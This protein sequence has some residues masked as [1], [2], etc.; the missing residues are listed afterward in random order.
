MKRFLCLLI[1]I[2]LILS[3]CPVTFAAETVTP[4][5][6]D[7]IPES[8]YII[9]PDTIAYEPEV[10]D[11]ILE[12]RDLAATTSSG[13][14]GGRV[15]ELHNALTRLK[16][17]DPGIHYELGLCNYG[18]ALRNKPIFTSESYF[19]TA[20]GAF[21]PG[22]DEWRVLTE[23]RARA[24]VWGSGSSSGDERSLLM[25]TLVELQTLY[26]DFNRFEFLKHPDFDN[27]RKFSQNEIVTSIYVT[28]DGTLVTFDVIPQIIGGRTLVPI[29]A[30]CERIGADVGWD[31]ATQ[32][33]TITRAATEIALTIDSAAAYVNG[34]PHTLD[35]APALIGG[36]TM[37]PIRFIMEQLCQKVE[38]DEKNQSIYITENMDFAGDSNMREWMLGMGA[39]LAAV[40]NRDPYSIGMYSRSASG[41]TFA[42]NTLSGSWGCDSREDV[43]FQIDAIR[44]F[45][46]NNNFLFDAALARSFT[47]EDY[48][49]I[50]ENATGM[51]KY[52][53]PLVV[54]LD[55]KWGDRGIAAW[56][57]FRSSHLAG[58]GYLAGYLT[59]EEAYRLAEPAATLVRKTF[60]S[61]DEAT[62]NY[63]D[64]YAYWGRIDVSKANN[65]FAR[66][67]AIYERL[68]DEQAQNGLLFDPAVWDGPVRGVQ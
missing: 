52:M 41:T 66:R 31:E 45:G 11:M 64:G 44:D 15:I 51:D 59:L 35:T 39:V 20:R 32:T 9:F 26:P 56:D 5:A 18:W 37:L 2:V 60:S 34:T 10:W 1:S 4:Y 23:L 24:I 48:A 38:W 36:R 63:L 17:N 46:H 61:W 33:A 7:W 53:W 58:W 16:N 62:E 19:L 55:K 43:L 21:A 28:V 30:V 22:T 47:A 29:R 3:F 8:E 42:R 65:D 13:R 12:Y 49:Y 14:E 6:P 50:L 54:A 40:N 25:R 67:T 27:F 57:W 68:K